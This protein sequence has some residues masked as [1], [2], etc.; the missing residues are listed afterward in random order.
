MVKAYTHTVRL[1]RKGNS[2]TD[3]EIRAKALELVVRL[4]I[5]ERDGPGLFEC[6]DQLTDYIKTGAHPETGDTE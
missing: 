1:Q 4:A 5:E 6:A 2:M 3:Q